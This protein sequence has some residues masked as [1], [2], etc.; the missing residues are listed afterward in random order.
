M[1]PIKAFAVMVDGKVVVFGPA[2]YAIIGNKEN[3]VLYK[4]DH[5]SEPVAVPVTITFDE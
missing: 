3:V 5:E 1:E 2:S 4:Q